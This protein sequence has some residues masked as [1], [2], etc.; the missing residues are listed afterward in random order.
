MGALAATVF[1]SEDTAEAFTVTEVVSEVTRTSFRIQGEEAPA[2]RSTTSM[3]RRT[4]PPTGGVDQVHHAQ[5]GSRSNP[6]SPRSLNRILSSSVTTSLL[7][8]RRL[9]PRPQVSS[10][11]V[12]AATGSQILST[13]MTSTTSS[14]LLPRP[15]LNQLHHPPPSFPSLLQQLLPLRTRAHSSRRLNQSQHLRV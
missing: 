1:N 6:N 3:M 5:S 11:L 12:L 2:S 8:P 15:L 4:Q 7:P 9:P 14:R 10:L 13:T